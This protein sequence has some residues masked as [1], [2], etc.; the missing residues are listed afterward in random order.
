MTEATTAEETPDN[1]LFRL[2][3]R[4]VGDPDAET[5]V[6]VGFALFFGG[7][8]LGVVGLGVFFLSGTVPQSDLT[9]YTY[10]EAA[11]IATAATLPLML[12]G[13]VVLLPGDDRMTYVALAGSLVCAGAIGLFSWAYPY[14]WNVSQPPDYSLEGVAVYA[15]GIVAVVGA[16]GA[17]LVGHQ[18]QRATAGVAA[19]AAARADP[20]DEGDDAAA[21]DVESLAETDYE[22]AM[23]NSD[24]SWGGVEKRDTKRLKLNTGEVDDVSREALENAQANEARGESVDDAVA[25]LRGLQGR[26]STKTDSGSGTDDQ[27]AALRELR[28]QQQAEEVAEAGGGS[29]GGDGGSL[30]DR[31]KGLFG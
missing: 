13:V 26:E 25:G 17:A 28:Q 8:A 6:Y 1:A 14:D 21:E 23:R 9:F 20:E 30:V 11:S 2:Y 15:V 4:Y 29:G 31:V 16:T 12:L 22:E 7:L 3:E 19:P 10:R 5:D 24:V 27:A 18:V